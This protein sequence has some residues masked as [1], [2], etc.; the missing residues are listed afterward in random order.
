MN[1]NATAS[2]VTNAP[3]SQTKQTVHHTNLPASKNPKISSIPKNVA[4]SN[5][6]NLV[7]SNINTST[8]Q[9]N[10]IHA[11]GLNNM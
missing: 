6:T 8:L 2:R 3:S 5:M 7:A 1:K 9:N 4:A 10:N 11:T